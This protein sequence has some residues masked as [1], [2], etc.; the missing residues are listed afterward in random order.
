MKSYDE[1]TDSVLHRRDEQI[2]LKNKRRKTA[3]KLSSTF[4]CL[5]LAVLV[6]LAA[7]KNIPEDTI[8][9]T[10]DTSADSTSG[11]Q[12]IKDDPTTTPTSEPAPIGGGS[13]Y[14]TEFGAYFPINIT[15]IDKTHTNVKGCFVYDRKEEMKEIISDLYQA[16]HESFTYHKMLWYVVQ[17][18]DLSR[19]DIEIYSELALDPYKLTDE[20]IDSLLIP[21]ERTANR[22]LRSEYTLFSNSDGEIYRIEDIEKLT[23]NEF[24]A[25]EF[26]KSDAVRLV[27][28]LLEL[29]G[30][31]ENYIKDISDKILNFSG[32]SVDR[33]TDN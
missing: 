33:N 20:Q 16:M 2:A 9:N 23:E 21:D 25:L 28:L 27:N 13:Q 5:G 1:M 32:I 7:V 12:P 15:T 18:L 17:G 31:S 19:E 22:M 24:A 11:T 30:Y 8:T 6:G 4:A 10:P 3:I 14:L 29:D 26:D